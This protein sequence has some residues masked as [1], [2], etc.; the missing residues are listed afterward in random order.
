MSLAEAPLKTVMDKINA[1]FD[2]ALYYAK[3][4][5]Q[6]LATYPN[7]I[8]TIKGFDV[9]AIPYQYTSSTRI[10]DD[11][12]LVLIDLTDSRSEDYWLPSYLRDQVCEAQKR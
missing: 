6:S 10:V 9:I 11:Y 8:F 2:V 12:C 4:D 3:C 5:V 1:K 7:I